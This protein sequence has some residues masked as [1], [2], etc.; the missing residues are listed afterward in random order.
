MS[1]LPLRRWRSR[2]V[3]PTL[4]YPDPPLL[5]VAAALVVLGIVMVFDASYFYALERYGDGLHFFRRQVAAVAIGGVAMVLLSRLRLELFER[6]AYAVLF[7]AFVLVAAVLIPGVGVVRGGARR[8][9]DFGPVAC[10]PAELAKVAIVLYL[11]RSITRKREHMY[12]VRLGILPHVIVVGL[13][14]LLIALQPDFGTAA[15]LGLIVVLMLY[16]GGARLM[17]LA[18]MGLLAVGGLTL[19]I[20]SA[21]YRMKRVLAFLNPEEHSRDTAFQLWQSLIAFGSGGLGGAGLGGSK[22]KMFYLPEAHNDFIFALIGEE[23]GLL[24]ALLVL[25]LFGALVVRGF[26]IALQHPQPF[27][28]LLAFGITASLALSAAVNI[29]VVL[30]LLPTK[31]LALP[32]LSYGGS[33]MVAVLA[34]VGILMALSRE[35]G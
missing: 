14:A 30:G 25:G 3:M 32:F 10:Q 18:S 5:L 11:A 26:R 34:Q 24:G 20:L 8:W 22:Q 27:G 4:N 2:V 9:V 35:A 28:S 19:A 6:A 16:V 29:G 7:L 23:L 1:T 15:M 13:F 31:G 33:A 12:T 17:H 21:S